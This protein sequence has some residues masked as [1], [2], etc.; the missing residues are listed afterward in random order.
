MHVLA[1]CSNAV[2]TLKSVCSQQVLCFMG[3]LLFNLILGTKH[4]ETPLINPHAMSVRDLTA[5]VC[6]MRTGINTQSM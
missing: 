3:V 6:H 2:C 5:T 4:T 1:A